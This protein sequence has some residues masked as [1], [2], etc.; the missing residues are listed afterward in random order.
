[1]S[2]LGIVCY[3]NKYTQICMF[4]Y[5][6]GVGVGGSTQIVILKNRSTL[7]LSGEIADSNSLARNVQDKL[8]HCHTRQQGSYYNKTTRVISE[9]LEK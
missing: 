6:R 2:L 4:I 9:S 5:W 7:N 8:E 3:N 1:M